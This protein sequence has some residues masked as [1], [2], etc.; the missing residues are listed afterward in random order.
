MK[1]EY[2]VHLSQ[3]DWDSS[4]VRLAWAGLIAQSSDA[5][6]L[7][8][9]PEFFD[10]LRCT[11]IGSDF[12]LATVRDAAG[13]ICCVVPLCPAR[14]GLRFDISG[15]VLAESRSRAVRILGS[16]P[17]LPADPVAHDQF[18]AE[19][20]EGF[21]DCQLISMPSVPTDCFLWRYVHESKWLNEKFLP[22]AMHG[23]RRCHIMPLPATVEAYLAK[24]TAKRRYNLR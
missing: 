18:F 24:F 14:S 12:Y 11:A 1:S 5:E 16:V 19:L 6:L 20:G 22:Y 8:K 7:G 13:S 2:S 9:C 4:E 17:L 10:H 15:H 21:S 3:D 23:V